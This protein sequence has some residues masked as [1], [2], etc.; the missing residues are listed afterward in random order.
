MPLAFNSIS[1]GRV[2]FGFFNIESDMLLLEHYF[3]FSTTFCAHMSQV[4]ENAQDS[5]PDTFPGT[6][7]DQPD[8]IGDLM[9]AIH[10]TRHTGFIGTLY[11]HFPFPQNPEAFKQNPEGTASRKLVE[12]VITDYGKRVEISFQQDRDATEISLA[13]FRFSQ[14]SFHQLLDYVWKGGLPRWTNGQPPNYVSQMKDA[15]SKSQEPL[16]KGM[17]FTDN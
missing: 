8:N 1:H 3:F 4:A 6:I 10:G 15:I 11:R 17:N 13:E 2:A 9:G 14:S 12:R 5:I 7:I 16:F